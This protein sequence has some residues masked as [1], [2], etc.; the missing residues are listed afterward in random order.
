MELVGKSIS[1]L[2]NFIITRESVSVGKRSLGI[3][4]FVER[5]LLRVQRC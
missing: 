1:L 3:I 2:L 4:T 5:F